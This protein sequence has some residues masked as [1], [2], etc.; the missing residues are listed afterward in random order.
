[1]M[2][3][4]LMPIPTERL[5][6]RF[7]DLC[8]CGYWKDLFSGCLPWQPLDQRLDMEQTAFFILCGP[9]GRGKATLS[10]ALASELAGLGCGFFLGPSLFFGGG[11]G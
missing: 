9:S 3:Q 6:L 1:M 2:N 5:N 7:D 8:G 10:M 4:W 11:L